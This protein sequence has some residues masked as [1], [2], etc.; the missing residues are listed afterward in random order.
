[1]IVPVR[2]GEVWI[3][4]KLRTVAELDYP[5]ELIEFILILDG[6]Q[7]R[8]EEIARA[9]KTPYRLLLVRV[10]PGGKSAALS[11]GIQKASG[12]ILFFTDIRQELEPSSLRRLIECLGDADVGAVSGELI[13]REGATH[14]ETNIGLYWRYEKWIRKTLSSIDS[15]HG[16][17]GCIYA[18]RR[19]LAPRV[20]ANIIND[21]MYIPLEALRRGYRVV[22][23]DRA[24]A[25][26]DP[27]GLD[28]EFH[29]KVRTLGGVF[30]IVQLCP[31]LLTGENR[32]R[33]HFVCHKLAR[34]LLPYA[35]IALLIASFF[36]TWPLN[37]IA[38]ASQ[39]ALYLLALCDP[40]LPASLG[41]VKKLSAAARTFAVM[42]LATLFAGAILFVP[43]E[44]LWKETRVRGRAG[45]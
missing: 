25:Y 19:E 6:S 37:A 1:M 5:H 22:F 24:H 14:E 8:T 13:I 11:A 26:D 12:E 31:W 20:G 9:A 45:R 7:D 44:R 23:D 28:A 30:Q 39:A 38:L 35:L 32:M 17:T 43:P 29:R 15:F 10:P 34:L 18:M 16:A 42:M 21:D 4:R 33:L 41:P 36:L 2:N 3:D 40:L 27:T